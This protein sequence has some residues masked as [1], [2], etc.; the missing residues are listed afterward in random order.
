[1]ERKSRWKFI[2]L[3]AVFCM[4][5]C[6]IQEANAKR[7]HTNF[8]SFVDFTNSNRYAALVVNAE[9]GDV[10]YQKN[11]S[12]KV[13]PA[14]LTKMMTLY[15]TF[16]A[17]SEGRLK[18]H[19]HLPISLKASMQPKTKLWLKQNQKITTHDAIMGLIIHSANDAAVVLAEAIDG[20]E[21]KFAS[22]MTEAARSLG[23]KNTT[24]M[25]ASGL[26][27]SEQL[28][29]AYDMARLAIALR[30]DYPEYYGLFSRKS[31]R[32]NGHIIASHNRVLNRYQW[33]DGLKTGFT[34][35]S[36]FNLV[37]STSSPNGKLVGVVMGGPTAAVRDNHM[38]NLLEYGYKKLN[39]IRVAKAT[40]KIIG[41][42]SQAEKANFSKPRMSP[43]I[44]ANA[45]VF[46]VIENA[47]VE[48]VSTVK[49]TENMNAFTV[50]ENKD[51]VV[52]PEEIVLANAPSDSLN[53]SFKK[54][55]IISSTPL[56]P[57]FTPAKVNDATNQIVASQKE[58][59]AVIKPNKD[60]ATVKLAKSNNVKKV[61]KLN[62]GHVN[63]NKK[64]KKKL[65]KR[66]H[67]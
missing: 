42:G 29:T 9:T 4:F 27:N 49:M 54:K 41:Q 35:A 25:N 57:Q 40:S 17:L 10:L 55:D 15:L 48:Q 63:K 6:G 2:I 18:L 39:T 62:V 12:K 11:A 44:I 28:S 37:T 32:F 52:L 7:R 13:Y 34:N 51:L 3:I 26:P 66:A 65:P 22:R 1:M 45:G 16:E 58:K 47:I 33:A 56:N 46:E 8:R 50:I 19:Q 43:A 21:D 20:S 23:M 38:I 30:R 61:A 14:S 24:F 5:N 31:F 53:K 64:E 59:S 67:I 36:G 60:V